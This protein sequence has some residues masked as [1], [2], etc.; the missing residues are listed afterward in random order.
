MLL[1]KLIVVPL[2]IGIASL[3][4]RRF[5][6]GMSGLLVGL[7]W[8]SGPVLMFLGLERGVG[9]AAEAAIGI[10]EGVVPLIT[11]CVGYAWAATRLGWAACSV[12]GVT[13]YFGMTL[14]IL[15]TGFPVSITFACV[16]A[17][18][19]LSAKTLPRDLVCTDRAPSVRLGIPLRMACA[20]VVVLVLTASATALGP[21][22]AGLLA[23]FPVYAG[24][25][26]VFAH[27]GDGAWAAVET[28]RG[29]LH[30]SFSFAIFFLVAAIGIESLGVAGSFAAA[31]L[32]AAA[33]HVTLLDAH[34]LR[35]VDAFEAPPRPHSS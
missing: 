33:M 3:A 1:F 6:P 10:I 5:G 11:F 28:L 27:R 16:V 26:A 20:T 34:V 32:S 9:F 31:G 25:L 15:G 19:A 8:T 30:G 14:L 35:P 29:V 12:L 4:R 2:L 22:L 7:P 17:A 24:I 13:S 18:L 23:P 21:R